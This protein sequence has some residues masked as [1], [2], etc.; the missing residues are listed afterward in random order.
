MYGNGRE[1]EV[2]ESKKSL[3]ALVI[4]VAQ[5]KEGEVLRRRLWPQLEHF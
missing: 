3:K 5:G 1:G 2:L 4:H